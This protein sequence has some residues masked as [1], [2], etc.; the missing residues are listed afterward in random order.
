MVILTGAL[1]CFCGAAQAAIV[2]R[3]LAIVNDEVVTEADVASHVSALLESEDPPP[4]DV[5]VVE[6]HEV[7]LRRLIEQRLMLQ[8]AK[9]AGLTVDSE[10]IVKRLDEL[11][12]RFES[13]EQ[14]R[15]SLAETALSEELLKEKVREQL[16]V[17]QLV[18]TRVRSKISVSPQE[19]AQEL[20]RHPELAR[21]GDRVRASHI[22]IRV[23]ASRSEDAARAL[24][25]EVVQRLANGESFPD[26]A[27]RYSE[28]PN[29]DA[30][31]AMD[32][33]GQGELLPELDAVLFRLSVGEVSAPIQSRLGFHLLR[34]EERRAAS[35]LSA[36]EANRTIT[37]QLYQAKFQEVFARWLDDLK[38]DAYIEI[39]REP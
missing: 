31:G 21:P 30:G 36:T 4:P 29:R 5:D 33:V 27:R 17:Q 6:M 16:L 2:N 11:R 32:W 34:M 39:L 3:V 24:M 28:D 18:D 10:H 14:F 38:R 35:S 23:T 37:Q 20:A 8:E 22:L 13:E 7:V 26:L 19:V 12:G 25:A 9:R 1:L 15:Q